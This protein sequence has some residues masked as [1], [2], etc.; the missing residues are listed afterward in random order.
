MRRSPLSSEEKWSHLQA[1]QA[2]PANAEFKDE[3]RCTTYVTSPTCLHGV[4]LPLYTN[5]EIQGYS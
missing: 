1:E 5:A 4:T 2:P 3:W